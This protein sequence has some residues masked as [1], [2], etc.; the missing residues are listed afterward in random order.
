MTRACSALPHIVR[1]PMSILKS[2]LSLSASLL[3]L[4][5]IATPAM[6]ETL[7]TAPVEFQGSVSASAPERGAP[8]YRGSKAVIAGEK[9]IPGQE[10]TLM[11]GPK[12]LNDAPIIVDAEGNFSFSLDVDPDAA[13]GLQPILVIAEKPAAAE[14]ITLKISPEIALAGAE[15]YDIA[16]GPV[17]RG[18]Y[19]VDY[20]KANNVIYV[21]SAVGRPPVK[22]SA[23]TK[24]DADS[25]KVLAEISPEAAPARV[26]GSEG[27]LFA[28]Y[29]VGVDDVNGKVWVTNTRQNTI[30]VYEQSDLS[31]VKQ[32]APGT[33]NHARD[34]VIDAAAGRAYAAATRTGNIE[35]FDTKTLEKLEPITFTSAKRGGEYS[36]MALDID[37]EAGKLVNVSMSTDELG[38]A[39][40]KTGETRV[41]ALPGAKAAS[42]VAYDAVDGLIFVVSQK[43]DNLLIVD[44]AKGE[45]LFDVPVGAQPLN[46]TFEPKSRLAYVA[47]RGSGTIAVV[48][49]K[50]EIV[51]NL[52][53]GN[54]TNQL[55]ADGE[56]RVW[57]VNKARGENDPT[58][59][60]IWRVTPKGE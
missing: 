15:N 59:D 11:R 27:G 52:D 40:L 57:A 10:I 53:A 38:I 32:F 33:V 54:A 19:Q 1:H 30:S 45:V 39:D 31:L 37:T 22:Q 34:V 12:A 6:A 9:L 2:R 25:L 48:N 7:F 16:N 24:L 28:L 47:N 60:N 58:G 55:R 26:D 50:G 51:A 18:L 8:I 42:G 13:I 29:G 36:A 14:V 41:L 46:V 23:L 35:V 43:S 21:T 3:A 4:A 56:G 44:E 5:L 49:T 20:S 17:T